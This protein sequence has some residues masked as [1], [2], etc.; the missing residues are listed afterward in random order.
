MRR[1]KLHE[2]AVQPGR[3]APGNKA[4][5]SAVLKK[6][7]T[8]LLKAFGPQGWWPVTPP[9]ASA[10]AYT[11]GLYGPPTG[12]G[13]LEICAG[14]I[15][16]QNT[17]W[18]NVEKALEALNKARL[19]SMEALAASRPP[20][21]E[22]A[23]RS[24]GYYRQKARRLKEFCAKVLR[25]HPGGLEQWFLSSPLPALRSGLL[26]YKGIGPET[27]DS[28]LLYALDKSTFV[29]DAYTKRIFSRHGLFEASQG[30]ESWRA[31]F[32]ASLKPGKALFNDY[33]AQIVRVAKEHCRAHRVHCDACPLNIYL[34]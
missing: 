26:S 16:T 30:Y 17:S 12:A 21:L 24:S 20:V 10:P 13:I 2:K 5:A 27:A 29:I 28:I 15:L 11:P 3:P 6:I 7:Y 4:A 23:V 34:K 22:K 9:G 31:L 8:R 19:L 32:M 18:K 33:H 1:A 14:A 25:E